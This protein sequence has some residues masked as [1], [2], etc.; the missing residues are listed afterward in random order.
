[1]LDL[2]AVP[3]TAGNVAVSQIF[4]WML[5]DK[6]SA[7]SVGVYCCVSV[8]TEHSMSGRGRDRGM[9]AGTLCIPELDKSCKH[10]VL[11]SEIV[12]YRGDFEKL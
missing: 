9:E 4:S 8:D 1:M 12:L 7:A 5:T 10:L 6:H 3:N 11:T 2:S